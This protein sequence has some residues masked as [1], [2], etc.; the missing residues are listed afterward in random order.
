[1]EPNEETMEAINDSYDHPDEGTK[2]ES[3][4]EF[5]AEVMAEI[6]F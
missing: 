1:M 5:I 4:D 3:A 6:R 2:Y